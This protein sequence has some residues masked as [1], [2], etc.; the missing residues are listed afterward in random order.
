M[1]IVTKGL[2]GII[3]KV[4]P[5][6]MMKYLSLKLTEKYPPSP[7]E[8]NIKAILLCGL[9]FEF[10]KE[11]NIMVPA[12]FHDTTKMILESLLNQFKSE[13]SFSGR[14]TYSEI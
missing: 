6:E 11:L 1:I 10:Q 5:L 12:H 4:I 9:A 13:N 2:S 14:R 7:L 8:R 3:L